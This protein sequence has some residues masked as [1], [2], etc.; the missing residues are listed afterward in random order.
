MQGQ[1]V[2][3]PVIGL[4]EIADNKVKTWCDYFDLQDSE[5]QLG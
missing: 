4:F 3:L 2:L 1:P 5:H